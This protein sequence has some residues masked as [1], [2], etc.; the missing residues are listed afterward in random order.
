LN[1]WGSPDAGGT[2]TN[3]YSYSI[4]GDP[5]NTTMYHYFEINGLPGTT[6]NNYMGS[7]LSPTLDLYIQDDTA[8]DYAQV[9]V[10]Y[11]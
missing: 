11:Y 7:V 4:G 9:A 8:I 3:L 2:P 5:D 10:W 6:L 1:V